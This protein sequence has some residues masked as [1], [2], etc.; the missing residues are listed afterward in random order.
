MNQ[1]CNRC[2]IEMSQLYYIYKIC[3]RCVHTNIHVC[4]LPQCFVSWSGR[5]LGG[6]LGLEMM[7]K[8]DDAAAAE[9]VLAMF[10]RCEGV[11]LVQGAAVRGIAVPFC[12]QG[13]PVAGMLEVLFFQGAAV[14]GMVRLDFC[15]CSDAM[16]SSGVLRISPFHTKP[17]P[18]K[19]KC[20]TTGLF[21]R[22][23]ACHIF[24][25]PLCTF[26]QLGTVVATS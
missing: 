4:R 8:G 14:T 1:P 7:P 3:S 19:G 2:W 20:C 13:A 24:I 16:S 5:L 25:I 26:T 9:P 6:I 21:P 22:H 18:P 15:D 12:F 17:T 11:D 23:S 10:G